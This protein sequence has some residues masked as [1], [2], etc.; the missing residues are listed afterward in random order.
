MIEYRIFGIRRSGNHAIIEWIASNYAHVIHYNDCIGW[1]SYSYF[2]KEIYGDT[3]KPLDCVVI[4]YEDFEP[5]KEELEYANT[6]VIFRDY[7]NIAASR[8]QS[9][10]GLETA[11]LRHQKDNTRKVRDVWIKYANLYYENKDKFILFNSW[12]NSEKYRQEL[13]KRLNISNIAYTKNL[14]KSKIG[15]GSSFGE[16]KISQLF[17]NYRYLLLSK[18]FNKNWEEIKSDQEIED[19][20]N[21]IF[22][23][24]PREKFFGQR[25]CLKILFKIKNIFKI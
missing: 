20:C 3:S 24:N 15:S 7:Y 19:F 17:I 5:S 8:L 2:K 9:S 25:I 4:S 12:A 11:C 10:R 23:L 13:S 14:P 22:G 16:N 1:E 6:Y 18:K 21:R